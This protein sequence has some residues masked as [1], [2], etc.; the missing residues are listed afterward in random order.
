MKIVFTGGGTAGHI[1]PIL[2]V[3]RE[4]KKLARSFDVKIDLIYI[5]P[6]DAYPLTLLK[7]EGIKVKRI[8]TGK[9]R[10]YFSFKNF[11]DL[12]KIPIG[13]IQSFF[14]L[15]FLAPDIVFS[16][17]GYGSFP[18]VVS[19]WIL[20]I[21]IFLHESDIVPGLASKIE[22]KLAFEIFTSFE[23]T[24]YFPKKK[25]LCVGNPIRKEI[26]S[27]DENFAKKLFSIESKKPVI[28]IIGGSQGAQYIN[29]V[30]IDI[31]PEL[32]HNFEVIHQTGERNYHKIK[33]ESEAILSSDLKA[34]YHLFP[35]LN[36]IQLKHALKIAEIVVSRAG[37]G[38]LFE[39]AACGKPAIL[40]P[41]PHSAQNHQLKNAYYF[42][43]KGG[44][45]VIEQ[46]NLKPHFF[47]ERLKYLISRKDLL[48]KMKNSSLSFAKPKAAEI[49]ANYLIEY[50]AQ[51]TK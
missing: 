37:S 23:Q 7:N 18:V 22:S 4:L 3:G 48:E 15:Y 34:S 49:I 5:G 46:G 24:E 36:E 26:L 13:L 45:E 19:A 50:L 25:V 32:L 27:G 47:L 12:F 1:F 9:L 16:K 31:L 43:K 28:L 35:F 6:N 33:A 51:I 11:F 10:R 2:A 8:W 41:L 40:I 44:G 20:G 14:W 29:E 17:G 38:S 42:A 30:V 21:P 39:I